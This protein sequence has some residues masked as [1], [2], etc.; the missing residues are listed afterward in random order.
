MIKYDRIIVAYS[1]EDRGSEPGVGYYW[2][3]TISSICE[4]E[5]I[6]LITRRNNN[7]SALVNNAT[8]FSTGIDLPNKLLFVKKI[9]G[10]RVYYL[11][12]Q[13]LVF[14]HLILNFSKYKGAIVHQ[15]TFTPMYYPPFFFLLPFKFIWGPVGGGESFPLSYLK[16]FKKTDALIELV[17]IV[18]RNSIYINP[19]FYLGCAK[20]IKIICSS[21]E[22]AKMIPKLFQDKVEIE[23]MVFDIDKDLE[24][25]V[26]EKNIIIANR[27]IDWKMTHLF[28]EAF[29]E[30]IAQNE[31]DYK[32][33]IIGDG[34]YYSKIHP[35]IDND[36]IIYYKKFKQRMDML[37]LLK[38]SSLFVSTSLHD[39][40]AASLLEAIS[41]GIPFL[42]SKS[43]AHSIYLDRG[44]GL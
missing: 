27:L 44:I 36:K 13:F 35:F 28:V 20:S 3:K 5:K 40:G 14:I 15:V 41:Y 29:S 7:V 4:N 43:G 37:D 34:P 39:S 26:P 2:T 19:L 31:T 8:L 32:L 30:F 24:N 9:I 16:S 22:S 23:L 21:P 11:F 17:R 1:C 18:I 10:T 6:L 25:I 12:W 42:V 38:K 33:I